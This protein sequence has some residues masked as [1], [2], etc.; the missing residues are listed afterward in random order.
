MKNLIIFQPKS[1]A[2]TILKLNEII[3]KP[4]T[5]EIMLRDV[6]GYL[7]KNSSYLQP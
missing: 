5:K 1:F 4:K 3:Q 7:M 6:F 2:W